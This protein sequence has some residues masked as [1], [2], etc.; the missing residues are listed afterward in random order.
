MA[1]LAVGGLVLALAGAGLVV[2]TESGVLRP[3]VDLSLT[4][5]QSTYEAC[6]G[7]VRPKLET[8]G[9]VTFAPIGRRTSRRY[10]G[11]RVLVR[12]HADAP[13]AAGRLVEFRFA[14]TMRPHDGGR[15]DLESLRV[16]TD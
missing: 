13:N 11:G 7:F 5:A 3:A 1:S 2:A 12:S 6:Q 15:W 10:G 16:S 8:P 4:D 14:C 9:P